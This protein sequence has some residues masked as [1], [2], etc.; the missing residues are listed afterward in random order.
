M[1]YPQ[2]NPNAPL[3]AVQV[4]FNQL[5]ENNWGLRGTIIPLSDQSYN[6][7][8]HNGKSDKDS[9]GTDYN[10]NDILALIGSDALELFTASAALDQFRAVI[11]PSFKSRTSLYPVTFNTDGSATATIPPSVD[12]DAIINTTATLVDAN[13]PTDTTTS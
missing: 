10:M 12:P 8:N 2:Q 5:I 3:S 9:N 7:V 13:Q 6:L 11:D 4:A 1:L